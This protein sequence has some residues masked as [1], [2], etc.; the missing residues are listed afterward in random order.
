MGRPV[1]VLPRSGRPAERDGSQAQAETY[2]P[3]DGVL[4][5]EYGRTYY[6]RVDEVDVPGAEP[7]LKGKIWSFAVEPYAIPIPAESITATAS[8]Q[9]PFLRT[10]G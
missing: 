3:P 7:I 10:C 6:W 8:G 1:R 9:S 2:F 4:T 5:V